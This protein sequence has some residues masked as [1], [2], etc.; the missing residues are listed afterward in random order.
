MKKLILGLLAAACMFS[1]F[2]QK[3]GLHKFKHYDGKDY[4]YFGI[5]PNY[6]FG[7]AG[8]ANF[9]N[10]WATEWDVLYTRPSAFLGYQHDWNKYFGNKVSVMYSLFAGDDDNSRNAAHR[11]YSFITNSFEASLQ[12][13]IYV[14]RG[15]FRRKTYDVYTFFGIAGVQYNAL[16]E[17]K[18]PLAYPALGLPA[19][20]YTYTN[21]EKDKFGNPIPDAGRRDRALPGDDPIDF[22]AENKEYNE[23]KKMWESSGS[24]LAIPFGVGVRF[25]V[26]NELYLG[27]EFG[28]RYC[29]GDDADF[30]DGYYTKWSNMNDSYANL[31][32]VLTYRFYGDDDC[33]ATYGRGKYKFKR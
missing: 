9:P 21:G 30:F 29:F 24:C 14:F 4:I 2:A 10:M 15:N 7:D 11:G 25:P 19:Y 8:G 17:Y 26:T 12:T 20:H 27:G 28:W 5:G 1:A 33:Y 31:S 3:K 13:Q 32:F 6:M 16:W 22:H 18:D 23:D